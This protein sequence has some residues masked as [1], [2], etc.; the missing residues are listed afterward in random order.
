[1]S[2]FVSKVWDLIIKFFTKDVVSWFKTEVANLQGNEDGITF[3]TH[4][5][6]NLATKII[7]DDY[8][9]SLLDVMI[10]DSIDKNSE[11]KKIISEEIIPISKRFTILD[12]R[13]K[14]LGE[15]PTADEVV[16]VVSDTLKEL[17]DS[18]P[19]QFAV[20]SHNISA[21]IAAKIT[22]LGLGHIFSVIESIW[23]GF[24]KR[25]VVPINQENDSSEDTTDNAA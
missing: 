25:K 5:V 3:A 22:G 18:D 10:P 19:E 17:K 1:M 2:T 21:L 4:F 12:T 24:T 8:Q 14:E 6:S 9:G 15:N 16:A 23:Q 7:S 11:I 20:L 13:V